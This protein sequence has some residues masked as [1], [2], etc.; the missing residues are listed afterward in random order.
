MSHF[1]GAAAAGAGA[2]GSFI[3]V[4]A[5]PGCG[6]PIFGGAAVL[7]FVGGRAAGGD[8]A[9]GLHRRALHRRARRHRRFADAGDRRDR[10]D[11]RPLATQSMPN[12]T[13]LIATAST[14]QAARNDFVLS[15]SE[16]NMGPCQRRDYTASSAPM[17]SED[18]AKYAEGL[19]MAGPAE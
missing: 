13:L 19:R 15:D 7:P 17:R 1:G 11:G 10:P 2:A 8:G 3:I 4:I 16:G 5:G 9:R 12:T 18:E 14:A 6:A